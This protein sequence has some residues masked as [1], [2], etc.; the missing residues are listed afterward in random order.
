MTS[1]S[2]TPQSPARI[3]TVV[4]V[5]MLGSVI[6]LGSML[7]APSLI[8]RAFSDTFVGEAGLV[9][10]RYPFIESWSELSKAGFEPTYSGIQIQSV[11]ALPE[12]RALRAV[13]SGLTSLVSILSGLSLVLMSLGL[14]RGRGFSSAARWTI[15]SLGV[16]VMV[17]ALAA[18]QLDA[19]A[20][21]LAVQQL[22]LPI[23]NS[24]T[25][26]AMFE[27]SPELVV[28]ALWDPLWALQ[29]VDLAAF[30]VGAV[31]AA[32]GFLMRDGLLLQRYATVQGPADEGVTPR[33]SPPAA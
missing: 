10:P 21:D 33:V 28:L 7:S 5:L 24:Y 14:L 25:D 18:P 1:M 29:R 27:D 2:P 15:G 13:E 9:T 30:A 4:L 6:L 20:V 11:E 23:F 12:S 8:S 3:I 26:S 31:I 22:G 32:A 19:L 16:V 17:N